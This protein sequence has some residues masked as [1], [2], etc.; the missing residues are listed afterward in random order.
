[1][2]LKWMPRKLFFVSKS[3]FECISLSLDSVLSMNKF[4]LD[5]I[6]DVDV[7][8]I[9]E[10]GKSVGV[11]YISKRHREANSKYLTSYDT[12]YRQNTLHIY[13]YAMPKFCRS[14]WI[15]QNVA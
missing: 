3:L 9:F 11:S 1:M 6:S 12:K 8:L 4:E 10:K 7:Y 15:M 5:L 13:G 2:Y 14:G